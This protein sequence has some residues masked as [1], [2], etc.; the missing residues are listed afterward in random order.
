MMG[1]R[2]G[3]R[4]REQ[5]DIKSG[6][7]RKDVHELNRVMERRKHIDGKREMREW[8]QETGRPKDGSDQTGGQSDASSKKTQS[9]DETDDDKELERRQA[10]AMQEWRRN[11]AARREFGL[12]YGKVEHDD[13]EKEMRVRDEAAGFVDGKDFGIEHELEHPDGGKVRYDYVNLREHRIIDRKAAHEGQ[14][15]TDIAKKYER[16]RQRHIEAYKARYGVEPQY[17]YSVYPSTK[18]SDIKTTKH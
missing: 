10:E 9:D 7:Q 12:E 16:Q 13:W 5:R 6:D 14:H 2:G 3:Y 4:P 18:D 15:V 1:E 11:P 17:E 8:S